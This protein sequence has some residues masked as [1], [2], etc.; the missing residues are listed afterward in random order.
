MFQKSL[1]MIFCDNSEVRQ[2]AKIK[3]I[4]LFIHGVHFSGLGKYKVGS[5]N[6]VA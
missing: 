2:T 4:S 5:K 6:Q 1:R 3:Y